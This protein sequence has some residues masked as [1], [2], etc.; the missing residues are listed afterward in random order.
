MLSF[1]FNGKVVLITG[2]SRGIGKAIAKGFLGCGAAV[3]LFARDKDA[4]QDAKDDLQV[5]GNIDSFSVD[6]SLY[7]SVV[8]AVDEVFRRFKTIDV[9]VNAAAIHGPVAFFP[10]A[11]MDSWRQAVEVNLLGTA[12]MMREVLPIMMKKRVG[13]IINFSGGGASGPRRG[14]SAYAASKTAVVRLT[15]TVAE[16]LR[17]K[18]IPIDINVIAPGMM[19]TRLTDE[20]VADSRSNV[21]DEEYKALLAIQEKGFSPEKTV[22]LCLFLASEYSNGLT[23]KFLS[24]EWDNWLSIPKR[25]KEVMNSDMYTLR[26]IKKDS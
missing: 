26:R 12:Y 6:V 13:K 11:N 14:L 3:A 7:Q 22:H 24:T 15:E 23:G 18:N 16:E 9:L 5:F 20:L 25:L 1:N 2:G 21:S 4:L 8:A 10:E 17:I 19:K